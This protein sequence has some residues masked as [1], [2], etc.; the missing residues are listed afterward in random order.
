MPFD[1]PTTPRLDLVPVEDVMHAGVVGCGAEA[2]LST[3]ARILADELIHCVIVSEAETT[4]SGQRLT[5]TTV[6][7]D[8]VVRAL[9]S[10]D[11]PT[12]AGRIA[13]PAVTV[14]PQDPVAT[15]IR[16]MAQQATSHIIVVDRGLPI[17]VLS[18]LDV[19]RAAGGR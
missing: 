14:E 1:V 10:G 4:P 13:T 3:V 18:A 16:R 19:A 12:T 7:A 8:D 5:W 9:A 11:T 2:S 6:D 15:A 17:G